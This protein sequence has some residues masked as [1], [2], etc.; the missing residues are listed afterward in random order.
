M[1][2]GDIHEPLPTEENTGQSEPSCTVV[3]CTRDRPKELERCLEAVS[4]LRYPRF[5]VLVVDNAPSDTQA[6]QIA[7]RWGARYLVEP[8]KGASRARNC[9]ARSCNTEIIAFCDDD[10]IPEPGWLQALVREFQD[11]EVMAVG[12]RII[13]LSEKPQPSAFSMA[14]GDLIVG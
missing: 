1:R 3:V 2:E 6:S 8:I 7:A 12:G 11:P 10:A 13:A 5:D 14:L 4:R 9:G